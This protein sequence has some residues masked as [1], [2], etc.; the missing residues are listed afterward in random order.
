[1]SR[2]LSRLLQLPSIAV[3]LVWMLVPLSMTLYF[4]F[5]K[6]HLLRP[7]IQAW[8][9]FKN[10]QNFIFARKGKGWVWELEFL[11]FLNVPWLT[12]LALATPFSTSFVTVI[13][14][15]LILV[16]SVLVITV[17]LGLAISVLVNREFPGRGIVRV[18]L[19]SP[20]FIMP[21]VNAIIWKNMMFDPIYGLVNVV[22]ATFGFEPVPWLE[23]YPL[24]GIIVMVAWQWTPFAIL[25]FMTSLQSE[26]RE[27]HEAARLDG[28]NFIQIFMLLT[29]PHLARAIAVVILIQMI[30]HLGVFAEILISTKGGPGSASSTLTFEI[31]KKALEG[32]NYGLA[33]AGGVL[34]IILANLV[35]IFLVRFVGDNLAK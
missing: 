9:G 33:A 15:T 16:G 31:Y 3:L 2:T 25:I 12:K 20:F 22:V 4:S 27:Q 10:Y 29:L 19:I 34:A 7:H 5:R 6:Y 21:A 1:M 18:M 26:D 23:L 13:G 17:V 35:S 30:F 32:F 8:A 24:Q 28:A 14:N 11:D